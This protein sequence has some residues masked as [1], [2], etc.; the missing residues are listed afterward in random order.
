MLSVLGS[1]EISGIVV[2][3]AVLLLV[4]IIVIVYIWRRCC[5]SSGK[6]AKSTGDS[7]NSSSDES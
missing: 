6:T 3:L 2:G 1:G 5:Q 4:F 7:Q